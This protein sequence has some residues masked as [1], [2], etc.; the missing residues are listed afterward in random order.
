MTKNANIYLSVRNRSPTM[1]VT[2]LSMRKPL[3]VPV[4][5]EI[6]NSPENYDIKRPNPY[7]NIVILITCFNS[8]IHFILVFIWSM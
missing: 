2:S 4:G 3:Q 1:E 6:V 5:S 8:S 7:Y